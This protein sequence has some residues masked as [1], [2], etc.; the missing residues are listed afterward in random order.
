[1][2]LGGM[3]SGMRAALLF[4]T[5]PDMNGEFIASVLFIGENWH[6]EHFVNYDR[7][8]FMGALVQFLHRTLAYGLFIYG[9]YIFYRMFRG[10]GDILK[11]SSVIFIFL[12]CTQVLIGILTVINS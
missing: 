3:M 4:P 2:F 12:L 7:G 10:S 1:L 5:W 8:I 11:K 9:I 6:W